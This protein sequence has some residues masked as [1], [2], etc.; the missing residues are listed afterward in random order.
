[1]DST[2]IIFTF[3][4]SR[5]KAFFSGKD[6]DEINMMMESFSGRSLDEAYA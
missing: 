3:D 4:I 6:S 5:F 2:W 1:M